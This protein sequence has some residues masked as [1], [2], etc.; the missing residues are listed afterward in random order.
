MKNYSVILASNSPRRKELLELA[1]IACTVVP[2]NIEEIVPDDE[3]ENIV[4]GL[5]LQKAV[6]VAGKNYDIPVVGADTMVF[7]DGIALGK[8]RDREDA[9]NMITMLQGKVHCVYTGVAIVFEGKEYCFYDMCKVRVSEMS[10]DEIEHF[11]DAGE[12]YD[13]SGSYGIQG[14]FSKFA[15]F[16]EGDFNSVI[17]LPVAAL[18]RKLKFIYS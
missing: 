17:G 7:V 11:V 18:Y 8:P 10:K 13:K 9:I 3:P 14:Q 15:E 16:T 5:A 2:S 6:A 4:M 12:S 1:G